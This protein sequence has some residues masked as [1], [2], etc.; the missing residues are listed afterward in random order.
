MYYTRCG[1]SPWTTLQCNN[2]KTIRKFYLTS[3]LKQLYKISFN[4]SASGINYMLQSDVKSFFCFTQGFLWHF[5]SCHFKRTLENLNWGMKRST[6]IC[7]QKG[8]NT[9]FHWVE[10]G[11]RRQPNFLD[12]K[13]RKIILIPLLCIFGYVWWYTVIFGW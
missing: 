8:L 1:Q 10:V 7:L 9:K 11:W 12:S 2:C 6:C 5:R 3:F 13:T 4:V